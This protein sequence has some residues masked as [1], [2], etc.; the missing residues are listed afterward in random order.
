MLGQFDPYLQRFSE[1][2][3]PLGMAIFCPLFPE[4]ITLDFFNGKFQFMNRKY[5][6]VFPENPLCTSEPVLQKTAVCGVC[7]Y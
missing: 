2:P 4:S 7:L 1:V 5:I 3:D 6:S